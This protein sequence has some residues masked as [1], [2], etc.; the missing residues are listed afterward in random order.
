VLIARLPIQRGLPYAISKFVYYALVLLV[1][2]AAITRAGVELNKFT[3]I[4]GALGVGV[5]F[6]LQN[7]VNNF[8]SG[9]ILLIERPIR[10]GDVVEVNGLIGSVGRI[11]ARSSTITTAQGAEVIVPNSSLIAN[12]VVNW[13][14]SSPWRRVEIPV[15]VAYGSDPEAI[16]RLLVSVASNHPDVMADPPPMAYFLGFGDSALNFE[17][18]FWAERQEIWFQLKSDVAV[19]VAKALKQAN[20]EIPFPQR[21]LHVR[22]MDV[23]TADL[24]R[25][26]AQ[27]AA[28]EAASA[29]Q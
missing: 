25:L 11:G 26:A 8:A 22:S 9:L 27:P 29:D 21:D 20:I 6:G 17:L 12:Q 28:G 5:G 18:R 1:L 4:T 2:F 3:V 7:I 16:I 15:G 14:L 23:A 24:R 10:V 13:T 19:A